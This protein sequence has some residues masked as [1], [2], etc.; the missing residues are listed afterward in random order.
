MFRQI[1]RLSSPGAQVMI[2]FFIM[3]LS[4]LVIGSFTNHLPDT[5]EWALIRQILASTVMFVLPPL[6][7]LNARDELPNHAWRLRPNTDW[8]LWLPALLTLLM[9]LSFGEYLVQTFSNWEGAPDWWIE[10]REAASSSQGFL[11]SI[12]HGGPLVSALGALLVVFIGPLGEEFFFRGTVQRLFAFTLKPAVAILISALL[13]TLF[14]SQIDQAASIFI[15][16]LFLGLLYHRTQS[17]WV[18]IVSHMAFNGVNYLL[19]L[20]YISWPTG[21]LM[22]FGGLAMAI[23]MIAI[24]RKLPPTLPPLVRMKDSPDK[25]EE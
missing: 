6:V 13:F 21:E 4:A 18:V 1:I 22:V 23:L 24:S 3:I 25:S 2:A 19:E 8:R 10:M 16:G 5:V 17:L 14:H 11:E 7:L 12:I 20:G 15:M 9:L